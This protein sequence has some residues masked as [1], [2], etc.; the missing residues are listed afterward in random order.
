MHKISLFKIATNPH[1][2][3][4]PC[5]TKEKKEYRSWKPEG[6][7]VFAV[8]TILTAGLA[9]I[10]LLATAA[11]KLKKMT[12]IETSSKVEKKIEEI[13]KEM[14]P[15][16][17]LDLI[18]HGSLRFNAGIERAL[19]AST[20]SEIKPVILKRLQTLFPLP[21][22]E[23]AL[24]LIK[25]LDNG[26]LTEKNYLF[27]KPKDDTNA[28]SHYH[29]ELEKVFNDFNALFEANKPINCSWIILAKNNADLYGH[30]GG[31]TLGGD[32]VEVKHI[33]EERFIASLAK[34][35]FESIIATWK[36]DKTLLEPFHL[37]ESDSS[38]QD[39]IFE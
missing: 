18:S 14:I 35:K 12:K 13:G 39:I 30:C 36:R 31:T 5:D 27:T 7:L 33:G 17:P 24:L 23:E 2:F 38:Y 10:I 32:S 37:P 9:G 3:L 4:Y 21:S 29:D 22:I 11:F 25:I 15:Q 1:H 16:N 8:F 26:I 20:L 28:R 6:V 19:K 34:K